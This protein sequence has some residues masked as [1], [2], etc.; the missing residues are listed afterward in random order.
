MVTPFYG[1]L[2]ALRL[3]LRGAT[4]RRP[5]GLL[6]LASIVIAVFGL[7]IGP[8]LVSYLDGMES[9]VSSTPAYTGAAPSLFTTFGPII[10]SVVG[11]NSSHLAGTIVIHG[12][13]F[14][15]G[16]RHAPLTPVLGGGDDFAVCGRVASSLEILDHGPGRHNWSAARETCL[17]KDHIGITYSGWND[18]RIVL[19]GFGTGYLGNPADVDYWNMSPGDTIEVVLFV[20]SGN[21]VLAPVTFNVTAL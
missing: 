8:G 13:G 15:R 17:Q 6:R 7:L 14:G 20:A 10:T 12:S 21:H 9:L 18:T 11:I 3:G 16:G 5:R 1:H 19:F 4:R 2:P